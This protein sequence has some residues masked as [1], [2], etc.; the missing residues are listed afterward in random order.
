MKPKVVQL[1]LIDKQILESYRSLVEGLGNY[2]GFGYEIVLHSLE[3]FKHSVVYI[4]NGEHTGR[5]VGAPITDKALELLVYFYETNTT[6]ETYYSFNS[7]G[8]PLKSTTIA[9]QGENNRIIGLLCMNFYMNITFYDFIHEFIQNKDSAKENKPITETFASNVDDM[10]YT[11][12]NSVK[13]EIYNNPNISSSNK[14]KEII[15]ALNNRGI[16]QI[17]DSVSVV[18][19]L[20]NISKNTVYLHLRNC[21]DDS[22]K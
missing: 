2:L 20:L 7:K 22:T 10:I 3:D 4:K 21:E 5:T 1:T 15:F 11:T 17:K 18:A 12:L 13:K 16:F 8:E 19:K 6:Q 14:N 9:I